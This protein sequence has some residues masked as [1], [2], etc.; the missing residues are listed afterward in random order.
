M[1]D[2][3]TRA[4]LDAVIRFLHQDNPILTQSKEVEAF[5]REWSRWLGVKHS[6]FVN[7]GSSANL[8]TI[9]ALKHTFGEGEIIVPTLTWVSDIASVLHCGMKPVFVDINPRTLGMDLDQVLAKI[10]PATK[11]VFLT[12]ILG[13]NGLTESFV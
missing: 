10:T 2:N 3:I 13:Y 6:V 1:S 8:I 5:E 11:A 4:D 9:A 12:H 7:S